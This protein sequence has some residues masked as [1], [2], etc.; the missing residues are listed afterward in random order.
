MMRLDDVFVN[1]LINFV[2]TACWALLIWLIYTRDRKRREKK[3]LKSVYM[4]LNLSLRKFIYQVEERMVSEYQGLQRKFQSEID[5][6]S[7]LKKKIEDILNIHSHMVPASH[8]DD[9]D[10]IWEIISQTS[11]ETWLREN[12]LLTLWDDTGSRW[13]YY[14]K[15][16]EMLGE[17][18]RRIQ[19]SFGIHSPLE[20]LSILIEL[21]TFI[22]EFLSLF[23][24]YEEVLSEHTSQILARC[25]L[26]IFGLVFKLRQEAKESALYEFPTDDQLLLISV[27]SDITDEKKEK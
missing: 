5:A 24:K 10:R 1:F 14:A 6:P 12:N 16:V 8:I 2:A 20:T 18:I 19:D 27:C 7:E 26:I 13:N 25:L 21:D 22:F 11:L 4:R 3:V 17:D 15:L 9:I 23:H